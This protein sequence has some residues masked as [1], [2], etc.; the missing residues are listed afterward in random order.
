MSV[1]GRLLGKIHMFSMCKVDLGLCSSRT[2]LFRCTSLFND[3]CLSSAVAVLL[4]SLTPPVFAQWLIS[5]APAIELSQLQFD[6]VVF[7][8]VV[9]GVQF[10]TAGGFMSSTSLLWRKSWFPWSCTLKTTEIPPVAVHVVVDVPVVLLHRFHRCAWSRLC[11][12]LWR[13]GSFSLASLFFFGTVY[14]GTR[15]GV[16]PPSGRGRGGGDAG[17]LLPGVLPP[18]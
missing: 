3:R 16:P 9:Q 4:R 14:T 2:R 17:S 7:V 8:P 13:L 5:M 1:Y 15:P 6:K 12:T 11:S 10:H 18:V